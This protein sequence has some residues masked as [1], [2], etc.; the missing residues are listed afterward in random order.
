MAHEAEVKLWADFRQ[1]EGKFSQVG[2][3]SCP[4]YSRSLLIMRNTLEL[5]LIQRF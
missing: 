3:E 4:L 1:R 2:T 5:E